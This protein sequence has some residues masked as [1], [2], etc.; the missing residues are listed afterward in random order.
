M[1]HVEQFDSSSILLNRSA[2][3]GTDQKLQQSLRRFFDVLA[4][5]RRDS[6]VNGVPLGEGLANR[7]ERSQV[8]EIIATTLSLDRELRR[9]WNSGV[10]IIIGI[11][12]VLSRPF[13]ITL[14]NSFPSGAACYIR[15]ASIN[16]RIFC[17]Q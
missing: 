7:D 10:C 15:T 14:P 12:L 6:R 8:A 16:G 3:G 17:V 9:I 4:Y 1:R 13:S 11:E 2:R 5:H